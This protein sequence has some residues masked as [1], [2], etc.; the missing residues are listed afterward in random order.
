MQTLSIGKYRGL[1]QC[2]TPRGAIAVLALDHRN[3]L[4]NS[5]RPDAPDQVPDSDLVAFKQQVIGVLAPAATAVLLDP[6]FGAVQCIASSALPGQVGLLAAVEASGYTG[7]PQAR[8]SGLLEGF[9]ISK[10]KRIG[11]SAVKMLVY[12][13]PDAPTAAEIEDLVRQVADNCRE[14]DLPLFLEPLSYSPDP[15]V[16]K[17]PA[18][19]I[20]RVVIETAQRLTLP[21][22]DILKAEFPL[23]ISSVKDEG[24]WVEACAELSAASRCPWVLLSASVDYEV[25]LRMVAVACQQGA[26]GV[27]VGRAVWKE[28][29]KLAGQERLTFLREVARPRM[30]R[31]TA[32]CQALAR[33]WTEFYAPPQVS[34]DWYQR[35]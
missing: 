6:Q 23:D 19:E 25:F 17:L 33:P 20:H 29:T 21:G 15:A 13:H 4:R 27:A 32:L 11:A 14:Q 22:V 26:S 12:Y 28:A 5:L 16:K 8:H 10:A 9:G 1:Q 24:R 30:E 31:V 7:D 34:P 18:G 2:S 35:Y 3:N